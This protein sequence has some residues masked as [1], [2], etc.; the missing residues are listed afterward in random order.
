MIR[1][2]VCLAVVALFGLTALTGCGDGVSRSVVKVTG[3][4]TKVKLDPTD[5]VSVGFTP[6][7]AGETALAGGEARVQ[8]F[9]VKSSAKDATGVAPGKYKLTVSITPYAGMA[10]PAHE[11]EVKELSSQY[12][13]ANSKLTYEVVAGKEQSI[14]IDLDAGTVT[15]Q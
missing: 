8:P 3:A 1:L 10:Q 2:P 13:A 9:T 5:A 4:S 15:A 12:N 7:G 11:Q 14:T 6:E